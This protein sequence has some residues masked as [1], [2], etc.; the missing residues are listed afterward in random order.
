MSIRVE[1][2]AP[3][4]QVYDMPRALQFYRDALGF[5][6]VGQSEPGDDCNWAMLQL[7]DA[8]LML[9]TAYDPEARPPQPDSARVRAHRDTILFFGC[10]D[11]DACYAHLVTRGVAAEPPRTAPYGMRQIFLSDP[12][13]F[14]LCF[15]WPAEAGE[16]CPEA[17]SR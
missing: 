5:S 1:G 8:T 16:G 3:L 4:V 9:N 11:L 14:G 17:T 6:V 12:D 13:G 2:V 15:Q 10:R 7:D